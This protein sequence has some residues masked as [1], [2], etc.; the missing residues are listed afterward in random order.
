MSEHSEAPQD[1]LWREYGEVFGTFDDLTLARW[2][3]QT[4]GQLQGRVWRSSHPLVGAYRLGAQVAHDRQIWLKRLATPPRDYPESGCCRAPVL[5]LITRDVI[6]H[7]LICQHC[8]GTVAA[9]D[10]LPSEMQGMLRT[11]AEKYAPIHQV[12]HWDDRQQK[13]AGDYDRALE[14]A[15][16]EAEQLL[17]TAGS[18]LAPALLDLYPA[19]LWEDHDE[20][21]DVRPEDITL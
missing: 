1:K 20:C 10:D 16:T 17:A 4:L 2:L 14:D 7:G 3:A 18:Q 19:V 5:P 8:H 6:D 15:A 13:R 21:L 9:F 12:A 11:W